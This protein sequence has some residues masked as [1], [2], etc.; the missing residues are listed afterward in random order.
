MSSVRELMNERMRRLADE[1]NTTVLQ[2][3]YDTVREPWK[4]A[5]LR[6]I[7][8][9]ITKRAT[10]EFA[11]DADDIAL[12]KTLMEDAEILEFQRAHPKLFW[13]IT[14]RAMMKEVKYRNSISAMLDIM[15][16]KERGMFRGEYEAD[17]AATSAI[18]SALGVNKQ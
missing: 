1:P 4:V 15:E 8:E 7:M 17:G 12:R 11:E 14:D 6:A 3:D 10:Q 13:G 16:Q 9:R 2:T 18:M 5:R